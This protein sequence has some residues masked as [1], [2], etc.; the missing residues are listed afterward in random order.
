MALTN[1]EKKQIEVTIKK[2]I[3]DFLN[4]STL[5]KFEDNIVDKIKSEL[6]KGN[7]RGDINEI[8]VHM[9]SEFYYLMWS[10]K[11]QW[12]TTLKNKK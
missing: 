3:K 5:K 9:M 7:L 2:E 1:A 11:N 8:I 10:K 6:S 4:A 12:Q